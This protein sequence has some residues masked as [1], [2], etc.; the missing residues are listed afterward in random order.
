MR[1]ATALA[2]GRAF[3]S[4]VDPLTF[5]GDFAG[6]TAAVATGV[7]TAPLTPIEP[8]LADYVS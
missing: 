6:F 2:A 7:A 3:M 5:A 4:G 8:P 1:V